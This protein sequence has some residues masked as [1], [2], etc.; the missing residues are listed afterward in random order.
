M[1]GRRIRQRPWGIPKYRVRF[2]AS[3][4]FPPAAAGLESPYDVEARYRHKRDTQWT[5]SMV[6]VSA[7]CD[8]AAPHRLTHV[9][10]MPATV[11]EAQCGADPAGP[12]R[13]GRAPTGAPG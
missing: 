7:T 1:S 8:P 2:K 4:A 10:T 11:H 9:P 12:H 13:Q 6:H 5:G 3:R